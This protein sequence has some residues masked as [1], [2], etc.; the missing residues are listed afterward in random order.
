MT[1]TPLEQIYHAV[2]IRR[3]N[4]GHLV[5][6]NRRASLYS[7]SDL[8][9]RLAVELNYYPQPPAVVASMLAKRIADV[10]EEHAAKVEEVRRLRTQIA[11]LTEYE[12]GQ[13]AILEAA[14]PYTSIAVVL[15]ATRKLQAARF[16]LRR[17]PR[18][19]LKEKFTNALRAW[20]ERLRAE[21]R[22]IRV[23]ADALGRDSGAATGLTSNFAAHPLVDE[24]DDVT[25]AIDDAT[26]SL[27]AIRERDAV[28]SKAAA[29]LA[30]PRKVAYQ[31][32]KRSSGEPDWRTS[33]TPK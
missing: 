18:K 26:A 32:L 25:N 4:A 23:D 12:A 1:V 11:E 28:L 20:I 27:T 7:R 10:R 33:T 9:K 22:R 17:V 8:L 29:T 6:R 14:T 30:H 2:Q 19:L 21:E 24:L 13:A 31:T 15:D 16:L 3:N 5:S